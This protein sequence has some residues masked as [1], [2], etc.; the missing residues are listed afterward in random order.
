MKRLLLSMLLMLST[1]VWTFVDADEVVDVV[2]LN[3]PWMVQ[4]PDG[5]TFVGLEV[6]LQVSGES[7]SGSPCA[8]DG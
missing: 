3:G 4:Q 8:D 5:S 1:A 6:P 2:V 7:F